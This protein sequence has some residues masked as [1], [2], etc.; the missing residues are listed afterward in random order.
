MYR[1]F[2]LFCL[3]LI[4]AL[5]LETRAAM[6]MKT[7]EGEFVILCGGVALRSWEKLRYPRDR[8]DNWWGNFVRPSRARAQEIKRRHGPNARVTILVYK[9]AYERRAREEGKPLVKWIGEFRQTYGVKL[10]WVNSGDDVIRYINRGRGGRN[11]IVSFDYYGHSNKHCFLLD[12]SSDVLGASKVFLHEND[13]RR[14]KRGAFAS[15][16]HIK[17]WG[18][19]TG[20][21]MSQ[22][23]RRATGHKMWGAVGKTDYG[24]HNPPYIPRLSTPGGYWKF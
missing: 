24:I 3:G 1:V 10:V 8:H 13:M 19:H 22:K 16:A 14:I 9:R 2:L 6:P 15:G 7:P 23:F 12:Y 17:S 4:G 11:K 5:T 20:E 18:C 21:S